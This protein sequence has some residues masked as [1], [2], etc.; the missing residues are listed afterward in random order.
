MQSKYLLALFFAI[1]IVSGCTSLRVAGEVQQGRRALFRGEPQL[2][3]NHFQRAAELDPN[4]L[5]NFAPLT[6][7]VWTYNGRA[8]Y[9]MKQ[10]G[11]SRKALERALSRT[12]QDHF[13]RLYLGLVL[14]RDGDRQRG[15]REIETA[16]RGFHSSLDYIAENHPDGRFWD[17]TGELRSVIRKELASLSGREFSWPELISSGEWLGQ[18]LEREIDLSRQLKRLEDTRDAEDGRDDN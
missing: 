11:E 7:G 4:Y 13:A 9:D 2:A 10:F 1:L 15:G 12:E 8:Y 18:Q 6:E 5:I 16:L 14:G 17:S 3:L